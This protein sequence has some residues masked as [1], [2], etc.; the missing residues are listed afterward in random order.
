MSSPEVTAVVPVKDR[1]DQMLRCLDALLAQDHPDYEI[2]VCDNGSTDGTAE[3]CRE[4]ARGARV[5]VRVEAVPGVLGAVRNEGARRARGAFVAF[6]DSDCLPDPGWLSAG[7]AAL[8]ANGRLGVVQGRTL[9]EQPITQGWPA[10]I[11]VERFSHRYEAC[12]LIFRR[13]ALTGSAGFDEHVG[14]F[15]EDTAA[16]YAVRRNGWEVAFAADAL[17][18]HDVTYPGFFW[19]LKRVRRNANLAPVV[20]AYPELRRDVLFGRV[21]LAARDARFL[22]AVTGLALAPSRRRALA[23]ALPY[24]VANAPR[25]EA[26]VLPRVKGYA[27]EVV[28]DAARLGAMARASL[29]HRTL[30][31]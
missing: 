18:H 26:W 31:L 20:R 27:Q 22:A 24:V 16:G 28:Y 12:N 13:E 8:R 9:P 11:C 4:R 2:L 25:G 6:T 30:V 14:H 1:R 7:S 29:R 17:V 15:W 10:T 23:L 5:P 3:A 21:F 19:H